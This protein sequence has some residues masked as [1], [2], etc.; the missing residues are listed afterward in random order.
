[1]TYKNVKSVGWL[2]V[3]AFIVTACNTNPYTGQQQVSNTGKGAGIGAA[4]GAIIGAIAGGGSSEER[5]RKA[6]I[7]AGIGAIAGGGVGAY[8]DS[9]EN[10]LRQQ[11]A[12]TGVSVTR[13]GDNI[14]LNMPGNITFP[15]NQSDVKADFYPV[16][17]SVALVL[18]EYNKTLIDVVGHTDSSGTHEY[19][20]QLSQRRAASVGQYLQSQ[21]VEPVRIVTTGMGP[22]Y[23]IADNATPAGKQQ[24][25]RVELVLRPLT[26]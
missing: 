9:Q 14:T 8:M 4:T 5:R 23:P 25:R 6:L 1:V 10:K 26:T 22:D 19:N 20:V 2:M 15:V 24:N 16:L 13:V 7:G 21:G 18:K 11:L 12:G 17:N 3:A